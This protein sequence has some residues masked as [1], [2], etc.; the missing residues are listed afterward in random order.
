LI[1]WFIDWLIDWLIDSFIHWLIDWLV[2]WLIDW[3]I[4]WLIDW[5]IDSFIP[6]IHSFHAFHAFQSMHSFHAF[7]AF[8]HSFIHLFIHLLTHCW[9]NQLIAI[10]ISC[11]WQEN[12]IE[13]NEQNGKKFL[14]LILSSRYLE[15]NNR[16]LH[17][18]RSITCMVAY[19]CMALWAMGLNP[20]R[21]AYNPSWPDGWLC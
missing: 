14:N 15:K 12:H 6:F 20:I 21:L 11:Q 1:D 17:R 9:I 16:F 5:L 4:G 3:L 7:H 19:H 18:P 2:G 13:K 8:I 10:G